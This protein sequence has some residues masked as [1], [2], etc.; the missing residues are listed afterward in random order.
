[1]GSSVLADGFFEVCLA[2]NEVAGMFDNAAAAAAGGGALDLAIAEVKKQVSL[3]LQV[4]GSFLPLSS[5]AT[6]VVP[7]PN[8][9][10][11]WVT[12]GATLQ[13][14]FSF[15]LPKSSFFSL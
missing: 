10:D 5:V 2:S 9:F 12:A 8:S 14:L 11:G 7:K 1:M 13:G 3:S 15:L 6:V 4:A